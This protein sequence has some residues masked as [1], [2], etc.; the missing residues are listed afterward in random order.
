MK[1][2]GKLKR[3]AALGSNETMTRLQAEEKILGL[4]HA[5]VGYLLS[6]RWLLPDTLTN[7]I[8]HHHSPGLEAESTALTGVIFLANI[9]S[10]TGTSE[11]ESNGNF[12]DDVQDILEKLGVS[13]N[14]FRQ[15]LEVYSGLASD[16]T[17]F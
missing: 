1:M 8:R 7:A 9:F 11:A 14:V 12:S 15:T 2:P 3:V 5:E 17:L 16:I 6:E 13:E 4:T 10:K